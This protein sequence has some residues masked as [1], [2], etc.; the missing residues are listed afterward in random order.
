MAA[1]Q[2]RPMAVL[3][4]WSKAPFD[5]KEPEREKG[6]FKEPNEILN[7]LHREYLSNLTHRVLVQTAK[8]ASLTS[9]QRTS[10]SL[11]HSEISFVQRELVT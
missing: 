1:Q 4:D 8:L 7:R 10:I 6:V 9:T 5:M 3:T 2:Q 11:K